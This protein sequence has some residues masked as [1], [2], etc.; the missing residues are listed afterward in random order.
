MQVVP[1]PEKA[2]IVVVG[3]GQAGLQACISLRKFGHWGNIMMIGDEDLIPYQRPPL[4]KSYLQGKMEYEDLTFKPQDWFAENDIKLELNNPAKH[5]DRP[6]QSVT[7]QDETSIQYDKLIFAT[8]ARPRKLR[9]AQVDIQGIHELRS[10][11]DVKEIKTDI[12]TSKHI[13]IVGAGYI[14]LETAAVLKQ[15]GLNVT[16]LET[17]PRILARVTS[18]ILS[19]FYFDL[20]KNNGVDILL[21]THIQK[22]QVQN[23]KLVSLALSNG[24]V[25]PADAMIVGIGVLPNIELAEEAG[26]ECDNGIIVDELCQSSAP[27][28]FAIG[29][30]ANRPLLNYARRGR[31]ES[32]HNAIEQGKIVASTIMEQAPVK[33]DCPWFWSDQYDVKLQIAGLSNGYDKS[34][35]RGNK[36]ESSFAV[37]YLKDDRVIA[38]DA[39]NSAA[40]FLS[41]K[42]I[43]LNNL[44]IDTSLLEDKSIPV[45][46]ILKSE[47]SGLI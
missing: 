41:G 14:G 32:V 30:C 40:D 46:D 34:I 12:Q 17:A 11:K 8:G 31:L 23:K 22:I 38:V 26:I 1:T 20:H 47:T 37:Y 2:N 9:D 10:L 36:E 43:I 44:N 39:I 21:E 16:V 13:V 29:D 25:I 42:K 19:E 7:L 6:N 27:N 45:K 18:P 33:N 3:C 35:V 24:R 5:I 28:I 15:M 4:S